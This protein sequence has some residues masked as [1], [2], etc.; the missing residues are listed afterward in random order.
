[1]VQIVKFG[2]CQKIHMVRALGQIN[3]ITPLIGDGPENKNM[4]C[5][6]CHYSSFYIDSHPFGKWFWDQRS[7][8][9]VFITLCVFPLTL[10]AQRKGGE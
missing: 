8:Q 10:L 5:S 6:Q 7:K 4:V 2:S 1:M 9:L 3:S